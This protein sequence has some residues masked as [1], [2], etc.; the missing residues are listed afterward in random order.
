MKKRY[1]LIE[2]FNCRLYK[3]SFFKTLFVLIFFLGGMV[4]AQVADSTLPKSWVNSLQI[5]IDR[6]I[7]P[8]FNLDLL[9]KEDAINDV[10]QI[11]APYR[12]AHK[13]SVDLNLFNSGTWTYLPNGDRIWTLNIVSE[14]ARTLNFILDRY[15]LPKGAEFHIYNSNR[16]DVIGP[17]THIE[18]Q[19]DGVL[20]T[21]IV[22]GDDVILEYYEPNEVRGVGRISIG[23]VAHGY[24]GFGDAENKF[25]KGL[26]DSGACNVDVMCDPNQGSNNGVDW[27]TIR[28]N[29]RHSVGVIIVN[30]STSCTGTLMNNVRED[31]TPYFLTADHCLGNGTPDGIGSSFPSNNWAVGF[32]WFTNTPDCATFSNT[33]GASFP[34]R[35][36]SGMTLR[37][38]R[39]ASDVA[40]F[41]LNQTPPA[42]WDLYYAGWNNS[43][44]PSTAQLGMHHPAGDIMKLSRNDTSVT[45]TTVSGVFSWEVANWDYGVTEGGSSG[46]C[47]IDPEGRIVGQLLGGFA[48][49]NGTVDNGQEDWYGRFDVSWDVG[50]NS[51]RRLRDWLDPDSTNTVT[52]DGDYFSTL[53]QDYAI[54]ISIA[55]ANNSSDCGTLIEPL[56]T[57]TNRGSQTITSFNLMYS[58]PTAGSSVFNYTGSILSG[59][60]DQVTLPSFDGSNSFTYTVTA[61]MPNGVADENPSNNTSSKD[62]SAD[63]TPSYNATN[64]VVFNILTDRFPLETSWELRDS[65]GILIDSGNR[66]TFPAQSTNYSRN[67]NVQNGECYEFTIFDSEDDGICCGFGAGSY[68]LTTDLGQLITTGGDFGTSDIIEFGIGLTASVDDEMFSSIK[69]FPN[70]SNGLFTISGI[71][72][73]E[74]DVSFNVF[75]I[76]G[77]LV[78]QG[79]L[80]SVN[81]Q[82]NLNSVSKGI[83]LADLS[84]NGQSFKLKLIKQ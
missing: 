55:V 35:I 56:V 60:T 7:M 16:T 53:G 66:G 25:L 15:S 58:D 33:T 74:K 48:G 39:G 37:A 61:T 78:K 43:S 47:L 62:L 23:E 54:D 75:N 82:I 68:N 13:M 5:D 51:A 49:C 19:E 26:N 21:W 57:I 17:Y 72:E 45:S 11:R 65:N 2:N 12:F 80:N 34:T 67:L 4:Q 83:Y 9:K 52:L 81:S 59:A 36:I 31:G 20:G 44:L 84:L 1:Y 69:V 3:V 29:Y 22:Y 50:F 38:N 8:S 30:G 41:E 64:N 27:T 73:I 79:T 14:G 10:K 28:D 24:R 46:S 42:S 77:K 71:E 32:D 76:A 6:E 70:P 18:N 63:L 40:L